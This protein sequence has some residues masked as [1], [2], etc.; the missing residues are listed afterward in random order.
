MIVAP[1]KSEYNYEPVLAT[2]QVK[3][4][5]KITVKAKVG[6]C[7]FIIFA[8]FLGLALT[9]RVIVMTQK[10]YQVAKLQEEI[11]A[12]QTTN[13]RIKL[14]IDQLSSL[15][16]VEKIALN[17]LGMT[18]FSMGDVELIPLEEQVT[19]ETGEDKTP[20]PVQSEKNLSV[21]AVISEKISSFLLAMVEASEL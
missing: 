12:L 16:R 14:E 3:K 8:F 11:A 19:E 18:Q 1:Q 15:D 4:K 21:L 2:P 5:N 6:I 7:L 10:G 17:D 13:A 9:S 20:A